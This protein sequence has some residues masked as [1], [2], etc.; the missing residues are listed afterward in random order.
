M[1]TSV[2]FIQ[3]LFYQSLGPMYISS[4]LKKGGFIVNMLLTNKFDAVAKNI[5]NYDI[6]AFSCTTGSHHRVLEWAKKIKS[7]KK[8]AFTVVGGPHPTFYSEVLSSES[9][10]DAICRGE[11]EYS[12]L[13]LCRCFPDLEKIAN[14]PG[15]WV[16]TGDGIKYNNMRDLCNLDN[17]PFPDRTLYGQLFHRYSQPVLASRGC[18]HNCSFCF[19][20]SFREIINK[21]TQKGY[22]VRYRDPYNLIEELKEIKHISK[23]IQFRDESFISNKRWLKTFL[24]LY[25]TTIGLPFDCQITVNEINEDTIR[26][27][28]GANVRCVFFG[29][30]SGNEEIRHK[31]V[32]KKLKTRDIISGASLLHKYNIP[33]RTY[34]IIGFP[35]ETLDDVYATIKLNQEIKTDYPW[36]SM[37][38]PYK[39]TE[40]YKYFKG[41][42]E[43]DDVSEIEWFF[44]K[45]KYYSNKQQFI[46]LHNL[47]ILYAKFPFLKS[48][49][50]LLINLP[51]NAFFRII[52]L[53]SY[54]WSSYKS[55]D[56]D[57]IQ[58]IR[59]GW[60]N[61]FGKYSYGPF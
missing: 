46:N 42:Y 43:S 6:F 56:I 34:N 60:N 11:G 40:I 10:L 18:P 5:N 54:A 58:F 20:N 1:T 33:F 50:N 48:A 61:S 8:N 59:H 3:H 38:T 23:S 49:T 44:S 25:R 22:F 2:L 12:M 26:L 4:S 16:R 19:N 35:D 9:P 21:E 57:L 29:I 15:I 53:T 24:K 31:I 7:I 30:E 36:V 52:Y 41:H 47:F 51:P 13:E 55:E 39:G 17:L 45:S 28:K 37:L 27:L 14:I 32:N